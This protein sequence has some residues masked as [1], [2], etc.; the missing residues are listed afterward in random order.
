M[1]NLIDEF[2][3]NFKRDTNSLLFVAICSHGGKGDKISGI[4]DDLVGSDKDPDFTCLNKIENIFSKHEALFG[5][6]KVFLIQTCQGGK[7]KNPEIECDGLPPTRKLYGYATSTSDTVIVFNNGED[8]QFC[9]QKKGPIF[10]EMLH[11]CVVEH[12]ARHHFTDI[13]TINARNVSKAFSSKHPTCTYQSTL[14]KFLKI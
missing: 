7:E 14:Q 4:N 6:P 2:A 5:Q 9:E 1:E 12:R 8:S 11:E 13:L 10:F 3:R